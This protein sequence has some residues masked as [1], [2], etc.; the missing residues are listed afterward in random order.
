MLSQISVSVAISI[1]SVASSVYFAVLYFVTLYMFLFA[2]FPIRFQ[3]KQTLPLKCQPQNIEA[4]LS[5]TLGFPV[6]KR[7]IDHCPI[8]VPEAVGF[9]Q[10]LQPP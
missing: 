2:S 6:G 5:T 7:I 8:L 9:S 4:M 10:E 3:H 1:F